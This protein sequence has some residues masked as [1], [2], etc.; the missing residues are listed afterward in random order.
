MC[1]QSQNMECIQLLQIMQNLKIYHLI[2]CFAQK[3]KLLF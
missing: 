1:L 2:I 3:Y